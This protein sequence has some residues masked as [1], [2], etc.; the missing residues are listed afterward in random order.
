[1]GSM[2]HLTDIVDALEFRS[3]EYTAY[4]DHE[5]CEV[6]LISG[7]VIHMVQCG[8]PADKLPEWQRPEYEWARLLLET[9]RMVALPAQFDINEWEIMAD[10][11]Q[12]VE[13]AS[14]REK[15]LNAI[16][17]KGAFSRFKDAVQRLGIRDGWFEFREEALREIAIE[18]CEEHK[19]PYDNK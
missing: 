10:F 16:H 19:I 1:M 14:V 18:W 7:H 3:D 5:T 11:S 13:D 8:D 6:C 9:D 2:V 15:L 4:L 12:S 17:G